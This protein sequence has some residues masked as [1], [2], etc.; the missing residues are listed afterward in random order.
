MV[1]LRK[2]LVSLLILGATSC[3]HNEN[4]IVTNKE[5]EPGRRWIEV[6][7]LDLSNGQNCEH[8]K[9]PIYC[10]DSEDYRIT[11]LGDHGEQRFYLKS[12]SD[13][14]SLNLGSK[15]EFDPK[16]AEKEQSIKKR[17]LSEKEWRDFIKNGKF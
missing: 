13:Y 9:I 17:S 2:S 15:F 12:K 16:I 14:E 7:R 6:K 8:G 10:V 11:V 4:F 1:N 3:A 5:Y